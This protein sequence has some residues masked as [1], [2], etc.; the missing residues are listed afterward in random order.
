V[1]AAAVCSNN[2]GGSS[3]ESWK[4]LRSYLRKGRMEVF[5]AELWAIW[6]AL[7]KTV[8]RGEILHAQGVQKTVIF[9]DSQAAV[10]RAAH[11]EI[12]PGQ[13]V[14]RWINNE[15]RA[16]CGDGIE[17]EIRWIPGH[18]GIPGNEEAVR[19]ANVAREG[20]GSTVQE[21]AFISATNRARRITEQSS[22]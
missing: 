13:Q 16:L 3:G 11:L 7:K 20:R 14:T 15:A 10:R 5:D 4:A 17:T 21:Q 12:G 22:S 9:G 2:D 6:I 8:K 18:S 1:G 19:Q